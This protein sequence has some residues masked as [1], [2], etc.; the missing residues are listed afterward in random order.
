MSARALEETTSTTLLYFLLLL[1]YY[2]RFYY[3][4][5]TAKNTD[6]LACG[7]TVA[8]DRRQYFVFT[9]GLTVLLCCTGLA[10]VRCRTWY[11][12]DT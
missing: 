7:A 5:T 8:D 1:Q 9:A 2:Y 12:Y 6:P 4:S 10:R 3:C 11:S